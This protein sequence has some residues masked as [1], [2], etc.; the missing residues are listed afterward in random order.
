MAIDLTL[1]PVHP[2]WVH[3]SW[4]SF[5]DLRLTD[6]EYLR[7]MILD[8]ASKDLAKPLQCG[9]ARVSD[10]RLAGESTFGAA[11]VDMYGDPLRG[12]KASDLLTLM[13]DE[14]FMSKVQNSAAMGYIAALPADHPVVLYWC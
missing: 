5:T 9:H 12:V 2:A 8:I 6:T 13:S 10:G 4:A 11:T 3:G 14:Y 1:N 7:G